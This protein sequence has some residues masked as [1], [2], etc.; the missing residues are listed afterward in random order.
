M[1]QIHPFCASFAKGSALS[2]TRMSN[3]LLWNSCVFVGPR[4]AT[5]GWRAAGELEKIACSFG[6]SLT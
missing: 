2:L 1:T 3:C 6:V 4:Y 5:M